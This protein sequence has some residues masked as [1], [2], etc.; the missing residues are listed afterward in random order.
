MIRPRLF[1]I[2]FAVPLFMAGCSGL[3]AGTIEDILSAGGPLDEST[4]AAGLKEALQVGTERGVTTT[5]TIDGFLGN[6]LIRIGLPEEYHKAAG[7]LRTAGFGSY[8][9]ELE[10][11]MN[12]AAEQA[13]AQARG[14]FW[15]AIKRM[16]IAD[17]F[18]IL[19][20]ADNAATEYFRAQTEAELRSRF[21]PIVTTKMEEVGL[22]RAHN[23]LM[24]YA[25]RVP[26]IEVP[27]VDMDAYVTDNALKGLF[28]VLAQEELKI[29][30]DP[31]ARTSAL[32]RR[33]FGERS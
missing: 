33:V 24:E 17:A 14:V 22:Y 8:V 23:D 5:S 31:A 16:T 25:Q 21:L 20:G 26:F 7:L 27:T 32:L 13:S 9:D 6:A 19:Q 28:T 15:D 29:R 2:L 11:S 4:V 10:V 1:G 18:A 12:R 3:N 30:E